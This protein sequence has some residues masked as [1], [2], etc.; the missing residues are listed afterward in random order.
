MKVL[1]QGRQQQGWTTEATCKGSWSEG[2]GCG[3]KLLVEERDI[4]V[5]R[6]TD[7]T[8]DTET[9]AQFTCMA[10]GVATV[11]KSVPPRLLRK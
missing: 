1:V 5:K 11:L 4:E 8:G 9:F 10:C 7:Y 6:H 2:G 3:A